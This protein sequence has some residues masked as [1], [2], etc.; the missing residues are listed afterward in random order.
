MHQLQ[1]YFFEDL[2]V[3][4]SAACTKTVTDA[5]LVLFAGVSGDTNPL[6]HSEEFAATTVFGQRIAPGMLTASLVSAVLGTK[7][8]G[9]GCV[10]M[11]QSLRFLAPVRI[12]DTVLARVTIT[13]LDPD[14][15]RASFSTECLVGERTVLDGEALIMVPSR[16]ASEPAAAKLA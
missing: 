2:S 13:A 15:R 3:G 16:A 9:P 4:M 10:Y 12:G 6:H 5:D 8:P 7:L 1:D 14:K 11:S